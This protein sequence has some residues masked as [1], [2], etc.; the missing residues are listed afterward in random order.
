MGCGWWRGAPE[1][2]VK[3][4]VEGASAD[5]FVLGVQWHPERSFPHD[6][7]SRAIFLAFVKA[8]AAWHRSLARRQQDF[9][10]VRN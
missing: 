8:A 3:E 4:A 9:E 5:H 2:G 10:S 7:A 6:A 1:D